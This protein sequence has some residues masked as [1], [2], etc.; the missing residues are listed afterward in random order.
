MGL[1][2][3]KE[4]RVV[5]D[6]GMPEIKEADSIKRPAVTVAPVRERERDSEEFTEEWDELD[7]FEDETVDEGVE[8]EEVDEDAF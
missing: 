2:Y 1:L 8:A 5:K 3:E 7:L 4:R 6:K